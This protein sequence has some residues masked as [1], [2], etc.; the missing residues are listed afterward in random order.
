M[1]TS[2]YFILWETA[3]VDT[4]L[5]FSIRFFQKRWKPHEHPQTSKHAPKWATC[6]ACTDED[7]AS[8]KSLRLFK[9]LK[10]CFMKNG[11]W[12]EGEL[13]KFSKTASLPG[14]LNVTEWECS[15]AAVSAGAKT[16]VIRYKLQGGLLPVFEG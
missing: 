2:G 4:A 6:E 15:L 10:P 8:K 13:P 1:K 12:I 3:S 11:V 16:V 7:S 14:C 9:L 5:E